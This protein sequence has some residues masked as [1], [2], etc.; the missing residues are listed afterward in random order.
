MNKFETWLFTQDQ[1]FI[2]EIGPYLK[3]YWSKPLTLE[4]LKELDNKFIH[5]NRPEGTN[6][7]RN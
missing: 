6:D 4:Q 1:S 5:N 2:N 3:S 7:R